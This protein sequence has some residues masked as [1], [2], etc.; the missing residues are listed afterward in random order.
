[1]CKKLH[2]TNLLKKGKGST[3]FPFTWSA[4]RVRKEI[5]YAF[6]NNPSPDLN[7]SKSNTYNDINGK[8]LK[9]RY[10]GVSSQTYPNE[11]IIIIVLVLTKPLEKRFIEN[12][13]CQIFTAFPEF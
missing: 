11:D 9:Y 3:F 7:N 12:R 1:M 4:D 10:Y 6:L 5:V 2:A 13:E 8:P